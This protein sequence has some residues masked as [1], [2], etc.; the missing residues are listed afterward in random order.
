MQQA[1]YCAGSLTLDAKQL[2]QLNRLET[3]IPI[4]RLVE[5]LTV[6]KTH[7]QTAVEVATKEQH[8]NPSPT[9]LLTCSEFNAR[10]RNAEGGARLP[11]LAFKQEPRKGARIDAVVRGHFSPKLKKHIWGNAKKM[12]LLFFLQWGYSKRR[13][14]RMVYRRHRLFKGI[15][16]HYSQANNQ[17][18][19]HGDP[20]VLWF[21]M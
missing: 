21:F 7:V 1:Y 4:S 8:L 15:R 11:F 9:V 5:K 6:L 10:F 17:L 19:Y 16:D 12:G 18:P 2:L 14:E 20:H 13:K 3:R